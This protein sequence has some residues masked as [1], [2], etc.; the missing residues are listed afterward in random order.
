MRLRVRGE[1]EEGS[2]EMI[3][4]IKEEEGKGEL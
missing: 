1:V 2:K 3:K 4:M